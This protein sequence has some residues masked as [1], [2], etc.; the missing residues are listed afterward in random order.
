VFP[1][2]D[3]VRTRTTPYV[4]WALI[5][6]N[7][8]VFFYSLTLS[9]Q[10]DQLLGSFR[11]SQAD[12][13][14]FDWGFVPACLGDTL[15]FTVNASPR[16]L[17]AICPSGNGEL[18]RVI[19]S[20][21][22]HAGWLHIIGNMLFLWIFGDNVE[23]RMGHGRYLVFYLLCGIAATATQTYF[24]LD[25]VLPAVG[26]SGAIAGVLGAYLMLYPTARVEV[27]I[28]PLIFIPFFIPAAA[29]IVIWFVTQLF[30]GIAEIGSATS[31]SG[32][33]WWAHVG[34]FLTGAVLIWFFKRP[35]PR[36]VPRYGVD[37]TSG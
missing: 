5:G 18:L 22:V 7:V 14:L 28:I 8:L 12:R 16:D 21:F 31:G 36:R 23:D 13:F 24:S 17:N 25:T 27:V 6:I 20:M 37:G 19:T 1:I 9:T 34:G 35:G 4:N 26:A 11:T 2:G 10:A 30:S 29:L 15:G 3:F 32:V 33:A